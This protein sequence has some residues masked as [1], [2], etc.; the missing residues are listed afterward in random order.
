MMI[1]LI[2]G[3][4]TLF[5][6]VLP[7]H[8]QTTALSTPP[9]M[10]S[11]MSQDEINAFGVRLANEAYAIMAHI[12]D[13]KGL[14]GG[15]SNQSDKNAVKNAKALF[16]DAALIQNARLN[17]GLTKATF[18]PSYIEEAIVSDMHVNRGA[19]D[20]LVLAFNVREPN[21]VDIGNATLMSGEAKPRLVVVRWNTQKKRWLVI[22]SA[23]FDTPKQ[24]L[25][26]TKP[27]QPEK[28]AQFK[29]S[30]VT[31]AKK[32]FEEMQDSS[33]AGTEKS[34]QAKGFTYVMADGQRKVQDGPIRNRLQHRQTAMNVEAIR[35]GNLLV[36]RLDVVSAIAVDGQPHHKVE[37]PR[38]LTMIRGADGKWRMLAIGIFHVPA[39][40]AANAPCVQPTAN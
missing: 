25:C 7:M 21:R 40:L 5:G 35:S 27:T 17:Y 10:V 30:D 12:G 16:D 22:S 14:A 31:L 29:T 37:R 19:D 8:A 13:P 2:V 33:F 11:T 6:F 18:R 26:T 38:L 1:R 3:V 24:A 39:T 32:L 4:V 15:G 34:V 28:R 23:D 9:A 36:F 20:V